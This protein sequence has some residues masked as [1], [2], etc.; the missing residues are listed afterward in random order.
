MIILAGL[1]P[2]RRERMSLLTELTR[3]F[4]PVVPVG[5][6]A[7]PTAAQMPAR[8][9][10]L[11]SIR[12][13]SDEAAATVQVTRQAMEEQNVRENDNPER[14]NAL[15]SATLKLSGEDKIQGME[16]TP[17]QQSHNPPVGSSASTAL[18]GNCES[19]SPYR[20]HRYGTQEG[21][22]QATTDC[23]PDY[24]EIF[25]KCNIKDYYSL[26]ENGSSHRVH[27]IPPKNGISGVARKRSHTLPLAN[28]QWS[29]SPR[30]TAVL[31]LSQSKKAAQLSGR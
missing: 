23:D 5:F 14:H 29:S 7:P 10:P 11:P 31:Q 19:L 26:L 6:S 20:L 24:L 9:Q 27:R 3:V 28:A 13:P 30:M 21:S 15:I 8:Q 16:G 12:K 22:Q 25:S 4:D 18:L 1:I 17:K 2:D